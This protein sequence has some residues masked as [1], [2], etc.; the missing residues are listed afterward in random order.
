MSDGNY[1]KISRSILDWEWWMDMNT[2]RVFIYMIIRAN[3]KEGKFKGMD[4]PRG[5]FVASIAS[6]SDGT[7]LTHDEVRTAIKHLIK[8]GNVTK[9]STNKY[10]VFSVVGYDSYQDTS[11]ANPKQ[12]PSYSQAIP[13]DRRKKEGNNISLSDRAREGPMRFD[14]FWN[15]YPKKVNMLNAQGEYTYVLETTAE[16]SEDDL[17]T[18]AKNY[19]EACSINHTKDRY[20][21]N[22]ENWLKESVWIDF[23]PGRYQKPKSD[24]KPKQNNRFNNF[25][26]REYD[27]DELERS[28]QG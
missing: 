16:L 18:A 2:T 28:L 25:D 4:I 6:I 7:G 27:F 10:T 22:P 21:K 26:Q 12:S 19:A 23:M 24:S 8:S 13:N 1:V 20:I 17:I 5:S 3:W 11:Q 14:E 9:Q 15:A